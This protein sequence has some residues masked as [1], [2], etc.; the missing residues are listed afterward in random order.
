MLWALWPR[1]LTGQ[2]LPLVGAVLLQKRQKREPQRRRWRV[3]YLISP[4][5]VDRRSPGR[6]A[7]CG[8]WGQPWE[9]ILIWARTDLLQITW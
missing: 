3:K 4:G 2:A 5:G 9:C 7:P 8:D 6:T 1:W